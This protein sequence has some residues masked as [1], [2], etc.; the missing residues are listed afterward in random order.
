MRISRTYSFNHFPEGDHEDSLK[1]S[2]REL[3]YLMKSTDIK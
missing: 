2:F 1:V 3:V